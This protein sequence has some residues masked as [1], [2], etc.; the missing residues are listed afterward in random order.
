MIKNSAVMCTECC[1]LAD[2]ICT[3]GAVGVDIDGQFIAIYTNDLT[4]V[5]ILSIWEDENGHIYHI[6]DK[7]DLSYHKILQIPTLG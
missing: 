1:T 7:K 2:P 4:K 5:S 3:C 6:G